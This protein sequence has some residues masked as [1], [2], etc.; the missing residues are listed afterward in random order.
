MPSRSCAWLGYRRGSMSPPRF[1]AVLLDDSAVVILVR[2]PIRP[3]PTSAPRCRLRGTDFRAGNG[4]RWRKASNGL[5]SKT[6]RW[7][8]IEQSRQRQGCVVGVARGVPWSHCVIFCSV[9][10]SICRRRRIKSRCARKL[11]LDL[12]SSHSF[13]ATTRAQTRLCHCNHADR[14]C[15]VE[16]PAPLQRGRARCRHHWGRHVETLH[17]HIR[18]ALTGSLGAGSGIGWMMA[19][20]LAEGGAHRVYIVGRRRERLEEVASGYAKYVN[21]F[22]RLV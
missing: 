19:K 18:H 3:V 11:A 22:R 2:G 1:G 13:H 10:A 9:D 21:F 14:D 7:H 15:K 16:T 5:L 17:R 20:T 12:Q 6:A 4:S 8:V